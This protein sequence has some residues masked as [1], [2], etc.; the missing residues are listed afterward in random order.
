MIRKVRVRNFK[1]FKDTGELEIKPITVIAGINSCGKSSILHSLTLL[2][3]ALV[4]PAPNNALN[5]NGTYLLFIS[6]L[7]RS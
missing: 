5:L 4:E 1:A 3:Q 6:I 2:K 7:S